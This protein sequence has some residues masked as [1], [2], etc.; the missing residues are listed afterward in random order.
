MSNYK[1]NRKEYGTY[2]TMIANT[3]LAFAKNARST[4]LIFVGILIFGLLSYQV[5]LQ[6]D[7]FPSVQFPAGVISTRSFVET[8]DQN[9][10][11]ITRPV[12]LALANLSEV[13]EVSSTTTE[14]GVYF[15]V[16]FSSDLTS[17]EGIKLAK[18]ELQ[19]SLKLPAN[20]ELNYQ[21]INASS[22]DGKNDMVFTVSS[23]NGVLIQE[24]QVKAAEIVKEIEKLPEVLSAEVIEQ[25]TQETNS[26]GETF[27][28]K[29][30]FQRIAYKNEE[31]KVI[32]EP[33]V[34]IGVVRKN[35]NVGV[36]EL[37]DAIQHKINDLKEQGKLDGY[38]VS[39]GGDFAGSVKDQISSLEQ[40]A[41][42]GILAVI[43]VAFIFISWRTSIVTAIFIPTVMSLTFITLYLTG[44]TLN[45]I[46]LFA[47]ILVLGLLVD[48]GTVVIEAIEKK[49]RDGKRRTDAI[50]EAI[51]EVGPADISGTIAIVLAFMPMLF[52]SGILGEFIYLIPVTVILTLF[53]SLI[54]ALTIMPFLSGIILKRNE[55]KKYKGISKVI[56]S[57]AFG[58]GR[59]I[60]K[61][62]DQIYKLI[63]FYLGKKVLTIAIAILGL[64]LVVLGASFSSKLEFNIFPE[65]KDSEQLNIAINYYPGTE[66]DSAEAIA[67]SIEEKAVKVIGEENIESAVYFEGNESSAFLTIELTPIDERDITS[68]QMT[69]KLKDEFGDFKDAQI[70]PASSSVGPPEE[71]YQFFMQVYSDSQLILENATSEFEMYLKNTD[72]TDTDITEVL[73]TDL[74]TVSK[75]N[76][77][78]FAQVKA[79]LSNTTDTRIVLD[80]EN[81]IKNEY[82]NGKLTSLDLTDDSIEF[83]KGQ[84]SE[85]LESFYGA[86]FAFGATMI[87]LYVLLVIQFNSFSQPM[88]VMFA[89]PLTFPGLFPGLFITNNPLSFFVMIGVIGLAGIVVNNTIVLMDFANQAR[90][91]G[92]GIRESI[93][94]AV[95]SR[96]RA[97]ATTSS[98]TI[99]GLLPLAL[100]EPFWESLAFSIIFGLISSVILVILAFPAYYSII[101]KLRE[102]RGRLFK[103]INFAVV[104]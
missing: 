3:S 41:L 79:K 62:G 17:E 71:D 34:S 42:E 100:S 28:F 40:N 54:T 90:K 23:A 98:T 86:I 5:F 92:K 57:I 94:G 19:S 10:Q 6:R 26:N 83:D 73:V 74:D 84:E 35:E 55:G 88:L 101:E 45:V 99:V 29:S 58:P 36:I 89:I 9:D 75:N 16:T 7:G 97:I 69:E 24:Q 70:K 85:N 8:P 13:E 61:L 102:I 52:I 33:A 1:T 93:S 48:D 15:F 25:I 64:V 39:Y 53:Y 56:D 68:K 63:Y 18:N 104:E 77:R 32:F 22:V 31:G 96:F 30:S 4:F 21:S 37:S 87:L 67:K 49:L 46:T 38:N 11:L 72:F 66:I 20:I 14:N 80:I 91:E 65:V 76:G 2:R 12:E 82:D 95:R 60:E 50:R 103:R 47:L 81:R 78:R 43:I 59:L 44:N 27:D 51:S